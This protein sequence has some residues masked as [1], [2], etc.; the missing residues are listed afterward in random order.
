MTV[1]SINP[2]S[3]VNSDNIINIMGQLIL[4]VSNSIMSI[5]N[6]IIFKYYNLMITNINNVIN[7]YMKI[8]NFL[9]YGITNI[10][11]QIYNQNI[12][13]ISFTNI[14][15]N[16]KYKYNNF[17]SIY[18][19]FYYGNYNLTPKIIYNQLSIEQKNQLRYSIISGDLFFIDDIHFLLNGTDMTGIILKP[20]TKIYV[21]CECNNYDNNNCNNNNYVYITTLYWNS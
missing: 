4:N 5:Y 18:N 7:E 20:K 9:N 3:I 10:Y 14:V 16:N 19:N 17:N 11:I 13:L 8:Y 1:Y 12:E 2:K 6:I 21:N 15:I